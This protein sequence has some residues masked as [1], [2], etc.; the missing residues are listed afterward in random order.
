[1]KI[2]ILLI[3]ESFRKGGQ[4][5]RDRDMPDSYE[6]QKNA[7]LS[8]VR[9]SEKLESEGHSVEFLIESYAT[10]YEED[11]KSWYGGRI[12]KCNLRPNLVGL[13]RLASEGFCKMFISEKELPDCV[14]VSRI[15][16][17]LKPMFTRIFDPGWDRL[18]FPSACWIIGN[19]HIL[20]NRPRVSDMMMFVP[21]KLFANIKKK[22]FMS[23]GAWVEY[24]DN[25]ILTSEEMGLM[26]DTYHDSDSAKDYNP[27]YRIVN[28]PES[29]W[30]HSMGYL[31][32][33]DMM[34]AMTGDRSGFDDWG[35]AD[36][37]PESKRPRFPEDTWE[38][39]HQ[40][41]GCLP[42]FHAFM[43][44]T[45]DKIYGQTIDH[46]HPDQSYWE[47]RGDEM[48][49]M[50]DKK[51]VCS[52]M[53]KESESVYVGSYEFNKDINFMIVKSRIC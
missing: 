8:H 50:D 22:M 32:G 9:L 15:D 47:I 7:C 1:M 41:K 44:F 3:G 39:W 12:E 28:R 37:V 43:N 52:Y 13:E 35:Y 18:M 21:G 10:R 25:K 14:L 23:H 46:H 40:D 45:K 11:L 16:A 5:S 38:W 48:L 42:H 17:L 34:P 6:D 19:G 33:D 4:G 27:L 53:K 31:V 29:K 2:K 30:W 20:S 51:R 24:Q 26:L 49:I 36:S